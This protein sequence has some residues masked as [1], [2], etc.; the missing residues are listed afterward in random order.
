MLNLSYICH[1]SYRTLRTDQFLL[2][3]KHMFHVSAYVGVRFGISN[4]SNSE[5]G[6]LN[7]DGKTFPQS[8]TKLFKVA[9]LRFILTK[10]SFPAEKPDYESDNWQQN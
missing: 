2:C 8:V 4:L 1:D 3:N 10:M 9:D 5:N 7:R 6:R